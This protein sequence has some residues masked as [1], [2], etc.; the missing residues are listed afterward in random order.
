MFDSQ[1]LFSR[2]AQRLERRAQEKMDLSVHKCK[3]IQVST[4]WLVLSIYTYVWLTCIS[5]IYVCFLGSY[6]QIFYCFGSFYGHFGPDSVPVEGAT[7]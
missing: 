2:V 4:V 7:G 3:S 1:P 5:P 6:G